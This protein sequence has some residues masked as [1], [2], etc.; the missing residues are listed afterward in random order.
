MKPVRNHPAAASSR[1][2]SRR[3]SPT[4]SSS[5]SWCSRSCPGVLVRRA[6][7]ARPGRPHAVLQVPAV[8]VPVP[9][10]GGRRCGCGPRSAHGSIELL[11]TQPITLWQAVLGKFFAAWLFVGIALALTFPIW[12]TIN[13]L[14]NP[15][16]GAIFAAY[17]GAFFFAGAIPR[18]RLVHVRASPRT[19][20]SRFSSPSVVCFVLAHRRFPAVTEWSARGRR[21]GWR[22]GIAVASFLTHFEN[23]TKGVLDLRDVLYF[24]L[25]QRLL[26]AREHRGARRAQIEIRPLTMFKKS[27]SAPRGSSFVGVLFVGIML[28][29][30]LLLRGAQARP[31]RRQALHDLRRH[32]EHRA[33]PQGAREPLLVLLREDR[34]A[35]PADAELRR[36]RARVARRAGGDVGRQAHAQG[37]RPAAVLRGRGPRH[38]ARRHARVPVGPPAAK[39]SISA[40]PPRTRRTARNP[41]RFSIRARTSSSSTT[42][43]SS[44]TSCRARRSR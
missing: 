35:D 1:A 36:A 39:S 5:S 12:I 32:R 41:S 18:G 15:D 43:P 40:S 17:L 14:G 13:Y 23:I 28:L 20:S 11:L 42:S 9:V 33:G 6:V 4:C 19:S 29:A 37:H 31:H 25:G 44:S 8:A 7:R 27:I 22:D 16:N 3:R 34:H 38:R 21:S 26:P 10:P 2:T 30:N 24:A